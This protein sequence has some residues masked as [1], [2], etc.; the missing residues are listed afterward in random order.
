MAGGITSR[1]ANR[2]SRIE[3]S[4]TGSWQQL[5]YYIHGCAT[6]KNHAESPRYT[7]IPHGVQQAPH[8]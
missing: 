3:I 5:V 7:V 1:E 4:G 8:A 2:I 6:R